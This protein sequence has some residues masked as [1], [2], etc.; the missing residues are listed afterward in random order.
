VSKLQ[1]FVLCLPETNVNW[2]L[3]DQC[4]QFTNI[5]HHTW[6]NTVS[7]ISHSPEDFLSQYQPGGTVTILHD[8]WTLR[9]I[10][11]GEDPLGLERWSFVTL[12]GKGSKKATVITAYNASLTSGDMTNFHQQQH[13]LTHLLISYNRKGDAQPCCQFILDLQSWL[14]HLIHQDHEIMLQEDISSGLPETLFHETCCILETLSRPYSK[15][16]PMSAV[17]SDEEFVN[18]YR[19]AKEATSSSPSGRHI[20][21]YKAI[22]NTPDLFSLYLTMMSIPFQV[23]I[24][25]DRWKRIA[26]IMLEKS[27]SD[28]HCHSLHIIALFESNLN[29]AKQFGSRPGRRCLSA[30]PTKVSCHDHIRI[31]KKTAGFIDNDAT[32]CY[33]HLMNNLVLMVLQKLGLPASVSSCLWELWDKAIH[34]I[35]TLY[36]T[37]DITENP[38]YGPS[39]GSMYGPLFWLLCYWLI[40]ESLNSKVTAMQF[41]SA[42]REV[43]V[44]ITGV[45]FVDDTGLGATSEYSFDPTKTIEKT[46]C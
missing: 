38:L 27:P 21:Y 24:V 40:V 19:A 26:D 1:R 3:T 36:G 4:Q 17:V 31:L 10:A 5:L 20:G 18:F 29:H 44:E 39:Q 16:H 34:L 43:L 15:L 22:L 42:C 12:R 13:V 2:N 46:N 33:D 32:G 9:V 37:S 14:E 35:K 11:K 7:S 6:K 41:I 30:V 23:G 28:L 8:N 45:S 25:P